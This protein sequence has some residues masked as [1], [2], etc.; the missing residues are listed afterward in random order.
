[1]TDFKQGHSDVLKHWEQEEKISRGPLQST[2]FDGSL[3]IALTTISIYVALTVTTSFQRA[4]MLH[5]L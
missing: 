4:P 1:M 2:L 5:S 3:S